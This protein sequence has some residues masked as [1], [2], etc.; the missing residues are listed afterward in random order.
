MAELE[1]LGYALVKYIRVVQTEK[2][3]TGGYPLVMYTAIRKLL[4]RN[5]SG[6]SQRV[7]S[8][9]RDPPPQQK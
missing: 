8:V 6:I 9:T 2:C 1:G 5:G 4:E 3:Y 7:R